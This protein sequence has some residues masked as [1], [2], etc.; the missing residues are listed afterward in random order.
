MVPASLLVLETT[1][2]YGEIA[3]SVETETGRT[4]LLL[5]HRSH[6]HVVFTIDDGGDSD[7]DGDGLKR[8]QESPLLEQGTT[9]FVLGPTQ[10]TILAYDFEPLDLVYL[11]GPHAYPFPE[12]EY[13]AVYPHLKPSG[14]LIIDD[15]QIPSIAN[16]YDILRSEPRPRVNSTAPAAER[17]TL[18]LIDDTLLIV[19]GAVLISG[20]HPSG[21]KLFP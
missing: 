4:T 12:L 20:P 5:S 15:V 16:M 1:L 8:V 7:S 10:R 6:D 19:R 11:D 9:Q 2:E 21:T 14:L 3:H 13:W 17:G 18:K